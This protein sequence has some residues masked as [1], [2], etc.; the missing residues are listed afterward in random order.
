[1]S[2]LLRQSFWGFLFATV[3]ITNGC[4][5][6]AIVPPPSTDDLSVF[7]SDL[8]LHPR[9][10]CE[11]LRKIFDVEYLPLVDTPDQAGF[12]YEEHWVSASD[13]TQ[14]CVWYLPGDL[15]R[16]AVLVSLGAAGCMPCYLFHAQL[17]THDGWSVVLYDYRGYGGSGGQ[18]D[19][20]A[21]PDDLEAVLDWTRDYTQRKRVT[22][23][24]V[25]LGTM[26]SVAVAARRP[27]AV[28]GVVLDSPLA[29]GVLV[30]RYGSVL[31]GLAPELVEQ[32]APQ[33]VSED[34]VSAVRQPLLIFEG[35]KDRVTPPSSVQIIYERAAGPKQLVSFPGLGHARA[36]FRDT[37][38]YL[39]YLESFLSTIWG[40]DVELAVE[41]RAEQ[42]E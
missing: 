1:M 14:L 9:Q 24:G 10:S 20:A 8:L 6:E 19:I 29:L 42:S 33:T 30:G 34:L 39:Y 27:D 31:G 28:N 15:D 5:L 38:T 40:Q 25:S 32:L 11:S 7:L 2:L 36:P 13:G 41:R 12:N 4:A 16:G 17:L 26:P 23:M 18:P 22:L 3:V 35:E 21:L 37:G